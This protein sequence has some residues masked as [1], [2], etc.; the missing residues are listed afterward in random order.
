MMVGMS[1]KRFLQTILQDSLSPY[2][3]DQPAE[4][5][6]IDRDWA[7]AGICCG[8][9]TA[10]VEILRVHDVRGVKAAMSSYLNIYG[11]PMGSD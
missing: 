5:S 8:L 10:G 3:R 7:T 2:S 6:M 4:I 9:A 11:D 1:R